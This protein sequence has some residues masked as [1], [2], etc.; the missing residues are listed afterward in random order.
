[1]GR[2]LP[3]FT[4]PVKGRGLPQFPADR[5]DCFPDVSEF[6]VKDAIRGQIGLIRTGETP[7]TTLAATR[8]VAATA[9]RR[10]EG[11]GHRFLAWLVA[12]DAG[13]RSAHALAH[14]TDGRLAD[15]G[16]TRQEARAEFA[17]LGGTADTPAAGTW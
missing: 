5:I 14:A 12:L 11:L 3:P 17:R 7:M 6:T 13:Y 16:I 9:A 1:M 8:P 10:T 2:A 4:R 15:M